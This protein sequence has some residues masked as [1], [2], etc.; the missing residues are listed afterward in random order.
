MTDK[1]SLEEFNIAAWKDQI[2]TETKDA[3]QAEY[4]MV[5]K[6]WPQVLGLIASLIVVVGGLYVGLRNWMDTRLN[7]R[8]LLLV[9]GGAIDRLEAAD[10]ALGMTDAKQQLTELKQQLSPIVQRFRVNA[11][12]TVA[13][14][15]PDEKF[16]FQFEPRGKLVWYSEAGEGGVAGR[17]Q[18]IP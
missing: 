10:R 15:F 13:I 11:D 7:D 14:P 18:S 3:L 16:R 9:Q 5:R 1:P 17:L 8:V 4:F 2:K 12:G 6:S